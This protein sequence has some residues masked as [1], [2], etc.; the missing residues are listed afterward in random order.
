MS[1]YT[2]SELKLWIKLQIIYLITL[3]KSVK[4]LK[5]SIEALRK[6]ASVVN[7]NLMKRLLISMML[8]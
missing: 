4:R 8:K 6:I 5:Y 7:L 3:I 1:L 2:M